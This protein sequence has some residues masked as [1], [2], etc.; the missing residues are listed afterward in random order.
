MASAAVLVRRRFGASLRPLS[1]LRI[2]L[3][4]ALL[5]AAARL[6]A[7]AGWAVLPAAAGLFAA[8]LLLLAVLGEIDAEDWKVLR[9]LMQG[10]T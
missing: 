6:L 4:S 3:A 10:S 9:S 2:L 1:A 7:P 5:Y 8:Y